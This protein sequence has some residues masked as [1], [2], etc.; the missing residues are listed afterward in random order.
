MCW[1]LWK[2]FDSLASATS[3][4]HQCA[5]FFLIAEEDPTPNTRLCSSCGGRV[6]LVVRALAFHQCGPGSISAPG[7][8]WVCWFSTL[9]WEVFPRVLR[10]S[11]LIKNQHLIWFVNTDCKIMI[12]AMLIWFPLELW[13]ALDHIHM[14]ICAIEILNITLCHFASKCFDSRS[15]FKE[16]EHWM[17]VHVF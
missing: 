3:G 4:L 7:V 6:I 1:S 13:S 16:R 5:L 2:N 12:W 17:S 11:P 15:K 9:L 14:L 8:D 10:F